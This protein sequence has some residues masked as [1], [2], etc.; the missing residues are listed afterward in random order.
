MNFRDAIGAAPPVF[1][2]GR[3]VGDLGARA[4]QRAL[5]NG[6]FPADYWGLAAYPPSGAWLQ[7]LTGSLDGPLRLTTLAEL[8]ALGL[9]GLVRRL[10]G[11][12]ADVGLLLDDG[13]SGPL[14]PALL[15]LLA[16]TRCRRLE[17][18]GARG[19]RRAVSRAS[20]L[21]ALA[22]MGWATVQAL[23]SAWLC[24]R[25]L[26]A[27]GTRKRFPFPPAVHQ[28][29]VL[30]TNLWHGLKAGVPWAFCRR[31]KRARPAGIR[32]Y[33]RARSASDG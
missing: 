7:E 8:R 3:L 13:T 20:G 16:L 1:G 23:L 15:T 11:V 29:A 5:V 4:A 32:V 18:V 27:L 2:G 28:A 6:L 30:R 17:A 33:L 26:R 25:E 24:S 14:V 19:S 10:W 9:P 21:A 12:R 22:R 31:G